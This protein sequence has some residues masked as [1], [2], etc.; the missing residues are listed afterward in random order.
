MGLDL[1]LGSAPPVSPQ[2]L[3]MNYSILE[4]NN[5]LCHFMCG[6][7]FVY[8]MCVYMYVCMYYAAVVCVCMVYTLT[9]MTVSTHGGQYLTLISLYIIPLR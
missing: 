9:C 7:L 4:T 1:L 6:H 8:V 3:N 2:A 5:A